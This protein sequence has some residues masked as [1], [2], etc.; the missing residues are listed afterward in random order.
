[1]PD[2]SRIPPRPAD[3]AAYI[4]R[5]DNRQL[6]INPATGEPRWKG[7]T[8]TAAES[9]QWAKFRKRCDEL[10]VVYA[11]KNLKSTLVKDSMHLLIRETRN[12]DNNPRSG[13]KLLSK[14]AVKGMIDDWVTFR[15]KQSTSLE[16]K[17][18]RN[19]NNTVKHVPTVSLRK[20]D[21][22]IHVLSVRNP[23]TPSSRA[24]PEA[25]IFAEV[26]RD[27]GT[28]P[29]KSIND[30]KDVGVAKRGIFRSRVSSP[31]DGNVK[32]YYAWY[33]TVYV[34]RNGKRGNMS[35]PLVVP[36]V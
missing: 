22:G 8:W 17:P 36:V 4:Q 18:V 14:I 15:I 19:R 5:T 24:L 35:Q 12:Y 1:M 25:I 33:V 27:V 6:S 28:K 9:E 13:H 20:I 32:K 26:F 30:Y 16:K 21:I 7:W 23:E 2:R 10:Y 29:P 3:F 34:S 31:A 11:D